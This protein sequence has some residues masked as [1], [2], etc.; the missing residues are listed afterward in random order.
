MSDKAYVS[1]RAQF[2]YRWTL[3]GVNPQLVRRLRIE[4]L[5]TSTTVAQLVNEALESFLQARV[6]RG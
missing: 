6:E 3:R 5:E 2:G 1:R 4:A